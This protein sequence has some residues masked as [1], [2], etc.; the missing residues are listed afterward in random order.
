M[1]KIAIF[2]SG[3]G[4]NAENLIRYFKSNLQINIELIASNNRQAKVL[5]RAKKHGISILTFNKNDETNQNLPKC[6]IPLEIL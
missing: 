4:T 5:R 6:E 3:N 2:A 1:N